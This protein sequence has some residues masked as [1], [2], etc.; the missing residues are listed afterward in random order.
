MMGSMRNQQA[1]W[2]K[3]RSNQHERTI[4]VDVAAFTLTHMCVDEVSMCPLY[5]PADD[6]ILLILRV[7]LLGPAAACTHLDYLDIAWHG[8]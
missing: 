1:A 2:A 6:V 8:G 5:I 3:P 7:L 4:A